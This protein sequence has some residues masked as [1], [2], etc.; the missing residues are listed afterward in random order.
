LTIDPLGNIQYPL[1]GE[2]KASGLTVTGLKEQ[3]TR[4]LSRYLVDP[5][6]DIMVSSAANL[7]IHVLGEVN[8]PGTFQWQVGM[9][10]WEG[11]AKAGGF[12]RDA[13]RRNILVIRNE[14][15]KAVMKAIDMNVGRKGNDIGPIAHLKNND[16]VYVLPTTIANVQRFMNRLNSIVSPVINIE[17][18]VVLYPQVRDV[19]R[20]KETSGTIVV[21]R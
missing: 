19:L 7:K 4:S 9:G 10:A 15:G 14:G 17:S 12:N 16:I 21:P 11:I 18:G 1:I 6:V 2:L 13:D 20:G 5:Q 8:A 3:M